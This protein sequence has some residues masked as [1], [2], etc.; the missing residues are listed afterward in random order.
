MQYRS[1]KTSYW[2]SWGLG[3]FSTGKIIRCKNGKIILTKEKRYLEDHFFCLYFDKRGQEIRRGHKNYSDV[4][5]L[6]DSEVVNTDGLVG[7]RQKSWQQ[8]RN[9][10]EAVEVLYVVDDSKV[11]AGWVKGSH[12]EIFLERK[13]KWIEGYI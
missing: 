4:E 1:E 11:R 3:D 13:Q 6:D 8:Y 10:R 12:V 2:K 7:L 5:H 9:A